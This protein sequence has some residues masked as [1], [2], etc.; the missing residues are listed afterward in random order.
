MVH[1][2]YSRDEPWALPGGWLERSDG[3][4]GSALQREMQ[5]ET[6][7]RVRVGPVLAIEHAG[8]AIVVLLA[9]ELVD[10]V[11]SF[12]RSP[13]ISDVAWIEP[14]RVRELSPMNARLLRQITGGAG[15]GV[16]VE[17][18]SEA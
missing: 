17:G 10:S 7:L 3:S 5:E 1:R 16:G 12:R 8:F 4:P 2:T 15:G 11:D 14:S 9:M 18:P 13:E 6:G